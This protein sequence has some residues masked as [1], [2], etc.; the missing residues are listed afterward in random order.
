MWKVKVISHQTIYD[1]WWTLER[2]K[3]NFWQILFCTPH[4]KLKQYLINRFKMYIKGWGNISSNVLQWIMNAWKIQEKFLAKNFFSLHIKAQGISHQRIYDT[5]EKL[6]EYLIKGFVMND[7]RLKKICKKIMV[8]KIFFL[9]LPKGRRWG[10][11]RYR[12]E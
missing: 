1:E 12:S 8:K 4:E 2:F 5:Y 9:H 3:K 6:K 10:L 11:W 7:E